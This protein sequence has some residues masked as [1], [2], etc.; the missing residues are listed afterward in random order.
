M[1]LVKPII[2]ALSPTDSRIVNTL[3]TKNEIFGD[4][5]TSTRV[6]NDGHN[7]LISEIKNKTGKRLGHEIYSLDKNMQTINGYYLEVEPEYRQRNFRLGEL[8]RLSSIIT[9]LENNIKQ[10]EI[11]S[12]NTAVYFHSKYKFI[13]STARFDDRDNIL[14]SIINNCKNPNDEIAKR[15]IEFIEKLKHNPSPEKQRQL[16]RETNTLAQNYIK[17]VISE[18]TQKKNPFIGAIDMKLTAQSVIENKNFFNKLLQKHGVD[19]SI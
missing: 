2:N 18:K 15:A 4:L 9:M 11:L 3:Y 12:K 13:P 17:R 5:V 19:Y 10:F 7:R 6:Y 1:T 8:L 16:T 14:K